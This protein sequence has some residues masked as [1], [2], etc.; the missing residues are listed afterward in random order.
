M[1]L[2]LAVFMLALAAVFAQAAT[3]AEKCKSKNARVYDAITQF[4]GRTDIVVPS[5]YATK[6]A[7][8]AA[9][10]PKFPNNLSVRIEAC[11]SGGTFGGKVKKFGRNQCQSWIIDIV[12]AT[13][14]YETAA[15]P[16][17]NV[18]SGLSEIAKSMSATAKP[19]KD[20]CAAY[21]Y[22]DCP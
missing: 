10:P 9:A 22:P 8:K 1:S 4:C 7:E 15:S 5:T 2:R 20:R 3:N 11:A 16:S 6:G 12:P 19:T 14:K 17:H 21:P 13:L 18:I